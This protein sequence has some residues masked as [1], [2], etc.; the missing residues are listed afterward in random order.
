M[1]RVRITQGPGETTVFQFRSDVA[2]LLALWPYAFVASVAAVLVASPLSGV[3]AGF[4]PVSKPTLATGSMGV[5]VVI[6]AAM[7]EPVLRR[8][9]DRIDHR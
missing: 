3:L 4:L 5:M 6:A 8:A 9:I 1:T 2:L 7:A